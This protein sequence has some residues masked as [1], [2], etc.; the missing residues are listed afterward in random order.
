[1]YANPGNPVR[2]GM[3]LEKTAQLIRNSRGVKWK[4]RFA[5]LVRSHFCDEPKNYPYVK[6]TEVPINPF[7]E[8]LS[9]IQHL[10]KKSLVMRQKN[11]GGVPHVKNMS[12]PSTMYHETLP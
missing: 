1:M 5:F 11:P 4:I 2:D 9:A 10:E 3:T 7:S 8:P 6:A 12:S